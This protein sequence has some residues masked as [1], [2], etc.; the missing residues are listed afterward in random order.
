MFP[1][2]YYR[3]TTVPDLGAMAQ[4]TGAKFLVLTHLIPPI[5]AEQQYPFKVPGKPLTAAD[6]RKA[7]QDGGFTGHIVVGTDLAT[8]RLPEK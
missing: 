7:A 2:A 3:Q 4:R 8:L 1:Y 6:Y 5:G